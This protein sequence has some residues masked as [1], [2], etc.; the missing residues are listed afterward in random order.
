MQHATKEYFGWIYYDNL[1]QITVLKFKHDVYGRRQT[2]KVTSDF[3][4]FVVILK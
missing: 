1:L 2:V 3:L 4:F